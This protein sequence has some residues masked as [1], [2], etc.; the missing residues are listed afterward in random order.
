MKGSSSRFHHV[1]DSRHCQ[2][3]AGGR[4]GQ[5][6]LQVETASKMVKPSE[7]GPGTFHFQHS[8]T[9]LLGVAMPGLHMASRILI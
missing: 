2:L 7:G 8:K 1:L 4:A 3:P 5:L 6:D 9:A